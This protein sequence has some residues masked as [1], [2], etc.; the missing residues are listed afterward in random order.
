[1]VEPLRPDAAKTFGRDNWVLLDDVADINAIT[2]DE[3][4][5][6]SSFDITRVI[7]ASSGKPTQS[8]NR[9]QAERRYGDTKQYERIGISNVTGGDMLYAFNDQAAAGSDG[10]KLYETIPEG[11]T[12]VLANRRA[13]GRAVAGTAGQF[14]NAFPVE[15]GP[16]FPADAGEGESGESAMTAA[17]AVYGEPAINKAI[18]AAP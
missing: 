13:I 3:W 16:S 10:K 15:F 2:D 7:F 11:A 1:M 17:F 4:N 6:A 18:V 14:Y 5:A 8:T 9:V 12:K